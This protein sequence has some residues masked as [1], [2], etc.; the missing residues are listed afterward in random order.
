MFQTPA[1]R[2]NIPMH[3]DLKASPKLIQHFYMLDLQVPFGNQGCD[4]NLQVLRL[5]QGTLR[6]P[7][8][9]KLLSPYAVSFHRNHAVSD[10]E[11]CFVCTVSVWRAYPNPSF[12]ALIVSSEIS[13]HGYSSTNTKDSATNT[14]KIRDDDK[15]LYTGTKVV[16]T[17]RFYHF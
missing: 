13:H 4:K 16:R 7:S 1:H 17:G 8:P 15:Y 11:K 2:D 5:V 14:T 9:E 6:S 3:R 12:K 10:S